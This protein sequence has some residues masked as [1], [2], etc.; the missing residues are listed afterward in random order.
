MLQGSSAQPGPH[1]KGDFTFRLPAGL[2]EQFLR[3]L[4]DSVGPLLDHTSFSLF[5]HRHHSPTSFFSPNVTSSSGEPCSISSHGSP[6]LCGPHMF[7]LTCWN[8]WLCVFQ[9]F[10]SV[11]PVCLRGMGFSISAASLAS[12]PGVLRKSLTAAKPP[13]PSY[14]NLQC[15]HLHSNVQ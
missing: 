6:A 2:A 3:L 9:G 13:L 15:P 14:N 11:M 7:S 12:V 8:R 1:L 5:L 4:H 10:H